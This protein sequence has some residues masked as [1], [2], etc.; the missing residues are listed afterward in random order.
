MNDMNGFP[1]GFAATGL[2]QQPMTVGFP[3]ET[4][5]R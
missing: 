2:L 3:Q 5:G 4:H 1:P